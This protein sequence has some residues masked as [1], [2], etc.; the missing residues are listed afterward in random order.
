MR[1]SLDFGFGLRSEHYAEI[2]SALPAIDFFEAPTE[3]Y[4]AEES[5]DLERATPC[6]WLPCRRGV[7]TYFRSLDEIEVF[8]LDASVAGATFADLCEG[9]ATHADGS[10]TALRAATL[11]RGWNAEG[12]ILAYSPLPESA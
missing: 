7:K 6:E 3:N 8:A 5:S 1:K 9:I 11:L 2:L 10:E 4:M 12:L